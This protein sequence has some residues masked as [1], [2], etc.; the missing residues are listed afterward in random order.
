[1]INDIRK[2]PDGKIF[3]CDLCLI[4]GGAAAAAMALRLS[5]SPMKIVILESGGRTPSPETAALSAGETSGVPY[6]ALADSRVRMLGG[7]TYRWGARSAPMKPIDF[8]Q[9]DWVEMSGWPI[10]LDAIEPYFE[11]VHD[12]IGLKRPFAY[13]AGVFSLLGAK[14]PDFDRRLVEFTAFQFG[15]NLVFGDAFA[16]DLE[17]AQNVDIYLNANVT[18]VALSEDRKQVVSASVKTLDGKSFTAKARIFVLACGGVDNPRMLLNWKNISPAGLC[19]EGGLVGRCFME[20]PTLTAGVVQSDDWQSLCDVFSPGLADGRFVETGLAPSPA[21]QREKKILNAVARVRPIVG[22]DATQ[23]LREIIWNARHRKIPLSLQWYKNEWLK[24][25]VDAILRDPF[26]IPLNILRHVQ[27]KPK[28]FK[29][30]SVVLELRTEQAP[31][32]ESRITLSKDKDPFGLSRAHLHW[33][34]T[35]LD[36]RTMRTLAAAVDSEL[37]RLGLG[38]LEPHPW[39]ET[40]DLVWSDDIVGGHHH[41][42]TTR[43]SDDPGEGVVDRNCKAH[44]LDNLYIAGSSVFS[45]A[46]FV[47]PT[48]TLLSLAMR[49]ADHLKAQL[50]AR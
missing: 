3:E 22:E 34:M 27:G 43:M 30:E 39:L 50:S 46:S 20:H 32:P 33:A 23:A 17:A 28:R 16:K 44:A 41:M 19:N 10:G 4:G 13:D 37:R 49:L 15:K 5:G 1:M 14:A 8:E 31:N 11:A 7:S 6:F 42:G 45:T 18:D 2:E 36:K 29:A 21:F 35:P 48:F 40:D 24:E 25:R 12:L 26:S 38:R 9:R 47:N